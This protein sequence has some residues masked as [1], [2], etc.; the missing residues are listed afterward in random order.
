MKADLAEDM[1]PTNGAGFCKY[2]ASR[3]AA[4]LFDEKAAAKMPPGSEKREGAG[5]YLSPRASFRCCH[6]QG[7]WSRILSD[8][9]TYILLRGHAKQCWPPILRLDRVHKSLECTIKIELL[10]Q[11]LSISLS[12]A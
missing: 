10:C 11:D 4:V 12:V 3:G 7:S 9:Q 1:P 8:D 5:Q 2:I 6:H